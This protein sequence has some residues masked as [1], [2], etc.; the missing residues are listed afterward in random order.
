MRRGLTLRHAT[1]LSQSISMLLYVQRSTMSSKSKPFVQCE[2]FY[3]QW[4]KMRLNISF[5]GPDGLLVNARAVWL[6]KL[7]LIPQSVQLTQVAIDSLPI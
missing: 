7:S 1:K 6:V 3:F 2:N 5:N 4:N